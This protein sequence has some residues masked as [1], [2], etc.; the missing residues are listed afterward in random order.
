[1]PI[2]DG[3][4]KLM[5]FFTWK[6]PTAELFSVQWGRAAVGDGAEWRSHKNVAK[7]ELLIHAVLFSLQIKY[8]N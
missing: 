6:V 1:M 4:L 3:C 8:S 5:P 7:C 2:K